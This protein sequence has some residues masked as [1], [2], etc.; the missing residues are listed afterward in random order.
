MLLVVTAE[1]ECQEVD[2]VLSSCMLLLQ[3]A[4]VQ[5]GDDPQPVQLTLNDPEVER[6]KRQEILSRRPSYR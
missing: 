2:K 5:E 1:S 4:S 3:V 6:K